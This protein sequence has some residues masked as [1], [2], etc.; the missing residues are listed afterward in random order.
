V[1]RLDIGSDS[2]ILPD[3]IQNLKSAMRTT[4]PN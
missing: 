3:S 2:E 4:T 1:D